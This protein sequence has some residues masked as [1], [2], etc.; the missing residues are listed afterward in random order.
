MKLTGVV[1]THNSKSSLEK[2]L[3]SITFCDEVI[4]V[5]DDSTDGTL[6]L[7]K[8]YGAKIYQRKLNSNFAAQRNFGLT[9]AKGKWVLFV[10]PDEIVTEVLAKEIFRAIDS[11]TKDGYW[12]Q[13]VDVFLS[14]RLLFGETGNIYFVRLAKKDAGKWKRP[15]HESW[16]TSGSLGR[17]N[18][19]LLHYPHQSLSH[20][21]N[22]INAYTSIEA[23]YRKGERRGFSWFELLVYP[24]AKFFKN[25]L[26][27]QGFRDGIPGLIMAYMMSIHSLAVR[28]KMY[29]K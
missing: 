9:K 22:K 18:N 15:V 5:D 3:S 14:K 2:T 20:F 24:T 16:N 12:I 28:V 4:V 8:K 7:A 21:F 23:V 17:L 25:Y 6:F 1:L 27:L 10:D 19:P 29:E 13:R 26:W 11:N